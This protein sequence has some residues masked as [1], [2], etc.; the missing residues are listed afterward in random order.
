MTVRPIARPVPRLRLIQGVSRT[1]PQL[2][3]WLFFS[4]LAMMV[5][6]AL[7]AARTSLD[8]SA[9]QLAEIDRQIAEEKARFEELR[10]DIA[11]LSSPRRIAPLAEQMGMVLPSSVTQISAPQVI[12]FE[13]DREE[14]WAE[15]KPVLAGSP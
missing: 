15:M 4:L 14:R 7:I 10:L 8:R 2:V 11:R 5:F 9:F 12:R 3:T 1:H 13:T 6:F